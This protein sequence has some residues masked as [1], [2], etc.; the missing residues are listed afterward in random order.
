[1]IGFTQLQEE[2]LIKWCFV[3]TNWGVLCAWTNTLTASNRGGILKTRRK[4]LDPEEDQNSRFSSLLNV[5]L[6]AG[7]KQNWQTLKAS[8]SLLALVALGF[9]P[10]HIYWL[11]LPLILVTWATTM[12]VFIPQH[13]SPANYFLTSLKKKEVRILCLC[14]RGSLVCQHGQFLLHCH[15]SWSISVLTNLI[16]PHLFP[17]LYFLSKD[18]VLLLS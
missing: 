1:M 4:S 17:H 5:V 3:A 6:P 15:F 8:R 16:P 9:F 7:Q 13:H 12:H 18:H 11:W 14:V 10:P 2:I